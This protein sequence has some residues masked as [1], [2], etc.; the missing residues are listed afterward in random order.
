MERFQR[1]WLIRQESRVNDLEKERELWRK[2]YISSLDRIYEGLS[3][4]GQRGKFLIEQLNN[5]ESRIRLWALD[6][7]SQ[8]RIGTQSKL[9]AELGPVLVKLVSSDNRDVRLATAKLLSLTGELS[10]A[11]RLAEQFGGAGRGGQ[12]GIIC[13]WAACHYALRQRSAFAGCKQTLESD[14]VFN[15]EDA[16]K[17][18]GVVIRK[19]LERADLRRRC[20]QIYGYACRKSAGKRN[21]RTQVICGQWRLWTERLQSESAKLFAGPFDSVE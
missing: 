6:K 10:S 17:A 11:E 16:K 14:Q 7:V 2:L 21:R 15:D 9:P 4:E 5:S 20:R 8:W 19:L 3:D 18:L 12:A 13:P 1:D